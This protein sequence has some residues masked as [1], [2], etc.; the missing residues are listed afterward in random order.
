ML[1]EV[2]VADHSDQL[3]FVYDGHGTEFVERQK[4]SHLVKCCAR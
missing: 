4:F 2:D 1:E 3:A